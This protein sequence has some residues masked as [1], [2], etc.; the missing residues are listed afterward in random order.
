MNAN[1][2]THTP[3]PWEVVDEYDVFTIRQAGTNKE[4][5]AI[6]CGDESPPEH[7]A[8]AEG[9]A[10]ARLVAAAPELLEALRG[11]LDDYRTDSCTF[12]ECYSCL[13]SEAA[14]K[15]TRAA[16]ARSTGAT[17]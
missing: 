14:L 12:P 11:M 4:I 5:A 7:A 2:A 17:P 8:A 13:M 16:I 3:G 6:W 9:R 1:Q 15:R 10:N